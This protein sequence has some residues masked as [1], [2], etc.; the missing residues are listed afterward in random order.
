MLV[1]CNYEEDDLFSASAA[2]RLMQSQ[3]TYTERL[4]GTT[5]VMEYYPTN[6]NTAPTGVGYLLMTA[7][8]N[9]QTVRIGM[10]NAV[11]NDLY[12]EDTSLWEVISDQGPVLSFNTYNRCLHFFSDPGAPDVTNANGSGTNADYDRG[13]GYEGNYEFEILSLEENATQSML[14]G[15]KIGKSEESNTYVRMQRL[16]DGID[17]AA[18][19]KDVKA[20]NDSIFSSRVP[21]SN[22][23]TL[24]GKEY[25][26]TGANTGI[27]SLYPKGGDA[28][29]ETTDHVFLVTKAGNETRLRFREAVER[30]D[31]EST[32]QEFRFDYEADEFREIDGDAVIHGMQ[33]A[34]A[35]ATNTATVTRTS[36]MSESF[37]SAID[38]VYTEMRAKKF[39]FNSVLLNTVNED[40]VSVTVRYRNAR[41]ATVNYVFYY[42]RQQQGDNVNLTYL[43]PKDSSAEAFLNTFASV[44]TLL[45][46]IGRE[47]TVTANTTRFNLTNTK[48]ISTSDPDL[49]FVVTLSN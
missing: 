23:L 41:G 32:V 47:Y 39:T 14:K 48:L 9:D 3:K 21:T 27:I 16:E 43:G 31:N 10:D 33:P 11:T 18:Y 15:K 28:I 45:G 35:L 36:V 6:R 34:E 29:T 30:D 5:W 46:L 7:F 38:A 37:K 12:T 2:E 17:F 20:F 4:T 42:S 44:E 26:M 40:S 13:N 24:G 25:V 8:G 19:L 22:F 49:W 1:S